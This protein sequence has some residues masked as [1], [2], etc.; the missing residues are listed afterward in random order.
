TFP[1]LVKAKPVPDNPSIPS[2]TTIF[3]LPLRTVVIVIL[4]C[5]AIMGI[6]G[7]AQSV[8]FLWNPIFWFFLAFD[9]AG[10]AA[11]ILGFFAVYWIIP[12]WMVAYGWATLVF[13]AIDVVRCVTWAILGSFVS[14][15]VTLAFQAAFTAGMLA[16]LFSLRAHANACRGVSPSMQDI[17]EAKPAPSNPAIPSPTTYFGLPLKPVLLVI[18]AIYAILGIVNITQSIG[19]NPLF[20]IF[21]I[22]D[23]IGVALNIFGFL[24]VFRV[25]PEWMAAYGWALIIL[26]AFSILQFVL[27]GIFGG[28]VGGFVTLVFQVL[29]TFAMMTCLYAMREY[30]LACRGIV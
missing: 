15:F 11:D 22:V 7:L 25:I 9:V 27:F 17:K 28:I 30:G 24:A 2:P 12:E 8:A 20:W 13:L 3:N 6:V 5:Y 14:A 1:E 26:L 19:L 29:F 21:I 23:V 18:L 10:L 4:A 16:C